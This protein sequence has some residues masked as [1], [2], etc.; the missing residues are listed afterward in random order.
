MPKCSDCRWWFDLHNTNANKR[1]CVYHT[2]MQNNKSNKL[3]FGGRKPLETSHD[4][5]CSE[6]ESIDNESEDS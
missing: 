2:G 6:Y 3:S 1:V 5:G 4:F